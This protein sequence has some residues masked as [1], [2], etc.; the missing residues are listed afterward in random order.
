[1]VG[2]W[3]DTT[4]CFEQMPLNGNALLNKSAVNEN[5]PHTLIRNGTT[6]RYVLAGGSVSQEVGFGI[7]D[8]QARPSGLTRSSCYPQTQMKLSAPTFVR[9]AMCLFTARKP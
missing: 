4:G 5:G 9:I 8:A 7:S 3:Q 6:G 1:M 2:L